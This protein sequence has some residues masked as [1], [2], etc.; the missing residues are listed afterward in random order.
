MIWFIFEKI[1]QDD[2]V[3]GVFIRDEGE[4][5]FSAGADVAF[6]HTA[7]PLEV[8]ELAELAIRGMTVLVE[9]MQNQQ[10][11]PHLMSAEAVDKQT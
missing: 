3:K 8:R 5:A 11:V 2:N 10:N 1:R 9:C 6:F 7:S 4:K